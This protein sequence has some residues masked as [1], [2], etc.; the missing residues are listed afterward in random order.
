MPE[1]V[2]RCDEVGQWCGYCEFRISLA[3]DEAL[4]PTQ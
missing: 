1:Y 4:Y 2:C 3:E